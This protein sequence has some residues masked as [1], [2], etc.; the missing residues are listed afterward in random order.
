MV[1]VLYG[2][3]SQVVNLFTCMISVNLRSIYISEISVRD[4]SMMI[5]C[6]IN[7]MQVVDLLQV[8]LQFLFVQNKTHSLFEKGSITINKIVCFYKDHETGCHGRDR[9]VVGF[10]TTY[11]I[12][13]YHHKCCD[14]E[15]VSWRGVQHYMIKFVS[16]LRH[17]GGILWA[18][19]FPPP[20]K[21]TATI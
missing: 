20:I 19:Q 5:N 4:D 10:T 2:T 16:D 3:H 14:F 6:I 17:V 21:L 8:G 1:Y 7:L 13:A 9:M 15:S 18:L 12:G 11:A